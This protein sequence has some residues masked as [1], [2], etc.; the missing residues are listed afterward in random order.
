M[1]LAAIAKTDLALTVADCDAQIERYRKQLADE[2]DPESR[3]I[4][5][6]EIDRWLDRRLLLMAESERV[7]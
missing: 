5:R 2:V 7:D 4:W 1:A 6:Y 3:A